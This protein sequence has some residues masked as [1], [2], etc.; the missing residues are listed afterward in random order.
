M[1]VA[2]SSGVESAGAEIMIPERAWTALLVEA[3]R[4]AVWSC[5]KRCDEERESFI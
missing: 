5:V 3:T 4:A 2:S 1:S